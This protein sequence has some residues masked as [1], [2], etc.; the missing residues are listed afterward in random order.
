MQAPLIAGNEFKCGMRVRVAPDDA[1]LLFNPTNCPFTGINN[2]GHLHSHLDF[3]GLEF[4]IGTASAPHDSS[5]LSLEP[6]LV[7]FVYDD[8]EQ[9]TISNLLRVDSESQKTTIYV[10]KF[11]TSGASGRV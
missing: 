4:S 1:V 2:F 3:N 11:V 8:G 6:I 7:T 9:D 10:T 5:I